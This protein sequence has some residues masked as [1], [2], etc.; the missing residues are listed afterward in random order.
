[1]AKLINYTMYNPRIYIQ[2]QFDEKNNN[3]RELIGM[4]LRLR[5]GM[6]L[7]R[8]IIVNCKS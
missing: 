8:I 2:I 6:L 4:T 7:K 3:G 5:Y 1:M